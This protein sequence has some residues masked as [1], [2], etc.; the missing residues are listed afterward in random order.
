MAIN[1]FKLNGIE[2]KDKISYVSQ[3]LGLVSE[4]PQQDAPQ[5]A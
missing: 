1:I 3:E 4:I 5:V 2:D